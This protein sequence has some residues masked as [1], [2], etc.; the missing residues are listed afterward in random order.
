MGIIKF[1]S[2]PHQPVFRKIAIGTWNNGGDP[3]VYGVLEIEMTNA[4]QF[5]KKIEQNSGIKITPSHLVGKAISEAIKH[6]PEINGMIRF[7]KIYLRKNIDIFYQVNVEGEGEHRVS[8]ANLSGTVLRNVDQL[9]TLQIAEGLKRKALEIRNGIDEQFAN[10]FSLFKSLPWWT[11]S[12]ALKI[13]SF[14]NYD[15]NLNLSSF[16]L[17]KDPFGSVMITNVGS[18]GIDLAFAPIVP[19]S[20]VPLLMAVGA[21]KDSPWVIDGEIV[22]RPVMKIGV[23]FDHRL[24]DGVHAAEIAKLFK[25]YMSNP[26]K[27]L[28]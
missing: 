6:R 20:K 23:T 2:R 18:F 28:S 27:Y 5:L 7:H 21:V 8:K 1:K 17:P 25:M 24:M 11:T 14:L 3:S 4:L 22:V 10:T 26:E 16:G 19:Y 13:F 12:I 15:L 9:T